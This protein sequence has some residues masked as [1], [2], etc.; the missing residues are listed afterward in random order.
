MGG[1]LFDEVPEYR[2]VE[3]DVDG[4]LGYSLREL[5]LRD[6]QNRLSDT[7]YTQPALFVVNALHG[8][9]LLAAGE[10]PGFF[11]GHSLG[12]YDAL[13]FG[14]AFDLLDG[15]RLV[16]KR[17]ELMAAARNG[18]MAAV[19][20]LSAERVAGVL[21][22]QGA[23]DL[24]VANYNSPMQTVLSGPRESIARMQEIFE[25]AGAQLYVSLPVSA[26]FHSRYMRPAQEEFRRHLAGF[27]FNRL[28]ARV[29]SNATSNEYPMEG[30]AAIAE[31]LVRQIAEPVRWTGIVQ[32]LVA[33]GVA[34]FRE[35]GPGNVLTRLTQQIRA[36]SPAA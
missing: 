5:C 18:G 26:A 2:R 27:R 14:G 33:R 24:D 20:G 29:M 32:M 35:V 28:G 4:L 22:E 16:Q 13:L 11:A 21:R 30:G 19:I 1:S 8:Y 7:R 17:G 6:P 36:V 31:L 12:E 15:V 10:R 23:S 25:K 9:K 3:S 34:T